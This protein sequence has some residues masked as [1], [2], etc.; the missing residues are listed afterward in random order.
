MNSNSHH[1]CW[2]SKYSG[3]EM[4]WFYYGSL[5]H[6]DLTVAS[7]ELAL[8]FELELHTDNFGNDHFLINIINSFSDTPPSPQK[9]WKLK[10]A[11]W[12]GY[13]VEIKLK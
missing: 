9:Y 13:Q 7:P 12:N 1:S 3:R 10:T 4:D 2:K 8:K 6:I 11:N 5:T